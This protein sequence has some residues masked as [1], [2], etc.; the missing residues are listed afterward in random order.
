MPAEDLNNLF[1]ERSILNTNFSP[2]FT[3]AI[4]ALHAGSNDAFKRGKAFKLKIKTPK[5]SLRG[6]K[7]LMGSNKIGPG[8][9]QIPH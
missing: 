7:L 9:D 1:L 2:R 6:N 5:T 3:T 8:N 4:S